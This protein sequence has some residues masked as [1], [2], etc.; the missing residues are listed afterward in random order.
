MQNQV[1]FNIQTQRNTHAYRSIQTNQSNS[2][3][4][5]FRD[6]YKSYK[7]EKTGGIDDI[8]KV[9][10]L[11]PEVWKSDIICLF[12]YYNA[13]LGEQERLM[14][15]RLAELGITDINEVP[16]AD[17]KT[18][19]MKEENE[20]DAIAMLN[21]LREK[22]NIQI[23]TMGT[24]G[25]PALDEANNYD[26]GDLRM[27]NI[28]AGMLYKMANDP[29]VYQNISDK[30]QR[31]LDGSSEFLDKAGKAATNMT[32]SITEYSELY[33]YGENFNASDNEKAIAKDAWEELIDY[34]LKWL[35]ER[36]DEYSKKE[37]SECLFEI[38]L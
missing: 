23:N 6:F 32:M 2:V 3:T 1:N 24:L 7:K 27:L 4:P 37:I 13:R 9:S 10:E 5:D 36:N 15:E 35:D 11:P 8:R 33:G 30:I 12:S 14:K 19:F 38:L 26:S 18:Y 28:S 20:A 29:E 17:F 34:L 25:L 22:F 16:V 31:W 21:D